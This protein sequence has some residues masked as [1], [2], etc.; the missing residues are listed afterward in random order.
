M[1][2]NI[3]DMIHLNMILEIHV[4]ELKIISCDIIE[5]LLLKLIFNISQKT[6]KKDFSLR[7]KHVIFNHSNTGSNPVAL[8]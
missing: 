1:V 7:V 8:R 6:P 2:L 4:L 5:L 3:G